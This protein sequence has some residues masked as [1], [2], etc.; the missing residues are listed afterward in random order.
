MRKKDQWATHGDVQ[1]NPVTHEVRLRD[2]NGW[3][4]PVRISNRQIH[5]LIAQEDRKGRTGRD[6]AEHATRLAMLDPENEGRRREELVVSPSSFFTILS[7][8]RAKLSGG[9]HRHGRH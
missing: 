4:R 1:V 5:V 6:K 8:L 9:N 7:R 3:G 2:G